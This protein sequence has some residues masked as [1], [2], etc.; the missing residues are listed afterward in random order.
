VIGGQA[1]A[2]ADTPYRRLHQQ[3][4]FPARSTRCSMPFCRP[5]WPVTHGT[6]STTPGWRR[7]ALILLTSTAKSS[8]APWPEWLW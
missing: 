3:R 6:L 8:C 1:Q 4:L 5:R 2:P 7:S